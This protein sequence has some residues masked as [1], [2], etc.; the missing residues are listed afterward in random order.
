MT[1]EGNMA[2]PP[3][4]EMEIAHDIRVTVLLEAIASFGAVAEP[5][6]TFQPVE[7]EAS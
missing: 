3:E 2:A 1:W 6:R 5:W 7:G 4:T